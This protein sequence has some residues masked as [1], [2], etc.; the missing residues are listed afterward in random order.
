[1]FLLIKLNKIDSYIYKIRTTFILK[2]HQP[3]ISTS[4]NNNYYYYY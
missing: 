4:N 2:Q 1:M 3:C